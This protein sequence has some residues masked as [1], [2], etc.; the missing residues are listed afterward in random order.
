MK[1]WDKREKASMTLEA[2]WIFGLSF[3]ILFFAMSASFK[4]YGET[5]SYVTDTFVKEWDAV[6]TFRL[7]QAGEEI[8][9]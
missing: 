2:S 7:I 4:L 1:G 8:L 5:D 3:V 9:H 6:Q